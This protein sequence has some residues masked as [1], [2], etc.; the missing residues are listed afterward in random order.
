MTADFLTQMANECR[1]IAAQAETPEVSTKMILRA[2]SYLDAARDAAPAALEHRI[3]PRVG[4]YRR[5]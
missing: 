3:I 1:R 5:D 2:R 4:E